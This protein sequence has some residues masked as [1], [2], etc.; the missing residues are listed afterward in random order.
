MSKR[1]IEG[2]KAM[3]KKVVVHFVGKEKLEIETNDPQDLAA[4][5]MD[6][7]MD[8]WVREGKYMIKT[9]NIAYLT[10]EELQPWDK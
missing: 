4:R 6:E 2:V 3:S 9:G 5:L 1:L 10:I 8:F 7:S